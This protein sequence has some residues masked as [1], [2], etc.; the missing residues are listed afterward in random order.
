[1]GVIRSN[2]STLGPFAQRESPKTPEFPYT[3]IMSAYRGALDAND[4]SLDN[5]EDQGYVRNAGPTIRNHTMA[6]QRLL[7]HFFGDYFKEDA[8][9]ELASEMSERW[10]AFAR[11]GDPNYEGSK[12]EWLPW[13]N[14]KG[15]G[16]FFDPYKALL[17]SVSTKDGTTPDQEIEYFSSISEDAFDEY[18]YDFVDDTMENEEVSNNTISQEKKLRNLALEA[19]QMEVVDEDMFKTELR[20]VQKLSPENIEKGLF[21][22]TM[23][24]GKP[25]NSQDQKSI[26]TMSITEAKEAIR[27]AQE[28]G[29]LGSGLLNRGTDQLFFPEIFELRW[30]PEGRL[31]ERDC[32]CDLWDRIRC[33][34]TCSTNT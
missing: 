31:L 22:N 29:A 25:R 13:M 5:L 34:Y 32:T 3:Q 24:K 18:E 4:S 10:A 16:T 12:G 6:F 26:P 17:E 20:R 30:P 15:N 33:K 11:N 8:D 9:E 23:L 27:I 1:M 21:W 28:I 2:Y 19:L 7:T 14:L